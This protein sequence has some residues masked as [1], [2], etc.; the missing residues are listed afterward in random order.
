MFKSF[1]KNIIFIVVN[2]NKMTEKNCEVTVKA[3]I[4]KH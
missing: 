2:T 4:S 1:H 3:T